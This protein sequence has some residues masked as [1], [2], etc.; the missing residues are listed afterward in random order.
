MMPLVVAKDLTKRFGSFTAVDHLSFDVGEGECFGFLG[1]NG[2]GKTTT[3]RMLYG[4]CSPTEGELSVAGL[5]VRTRLREVKRLVGV[6]PQENN[7]DPDLTVLENLL[8][9]A[10]YFDLPRA[11]AEGR[12]LEL[13][14]F[15][16]LDKRADSRIEELSFGMKRRLVIA[17]S[18][19][20]RPRL[21]VLDEPTTGLD[22]QARHLIWERLRLLQQEGVTMILTTHYMEEATRLC[23]RVAI[24][25]RGRILRLGSPLALV[26]A[27][28]GTEVIE[29]R[30][31]E[32][33][34][35][36]VLAILQEGQ[37]S[38]E[39]CG[40]T[41]YIYCPNGARELLASLDRLLG[42]RPTPQGGPSILLRPATLEDLFLKLA[43]RT[44]R[45]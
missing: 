19:L 44:L 9:Y 30:I 10:R 4:L 45:E 36:K 38:F 18:L 15:V 5:D 42:F 34:R 22:P 39:R 41:F 21:L 40:D 31:P 35:E 12:A 28:V 32:G 16:E 1:P 8:A 26:E 24:L 2:A 7:L 14:R 3:I 43:G 6:V 37:Q 25:D 17:R 33:E 13:L 29:V 27:E 23:H 11:E 20:H